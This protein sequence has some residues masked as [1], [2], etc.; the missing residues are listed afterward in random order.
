LPVNEG[1]L[2][3]HG[4][5]VKVVA[6]KP[7][8]VPEPFCLSSDS[9]RIDMHTEPE[10]ITFHANPVPKAILEGVVVCIIST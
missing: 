8:T 3:R 1:V 4:I 5:G 6:R 10:T 9:H 7:T 2:T